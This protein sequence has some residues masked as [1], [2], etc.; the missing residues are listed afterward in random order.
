MPESIVS[1]ANHPLISTENDTGAI[2]IPLPLVAG[3]FAIAAAILVV[4]GTA[5]LARPDQTVDA[6][7]AATLPAS[8]P[9]VATIAVGELAAG[10][11]ALVIGGP[12]PAIAVLGLYLGFLAFILISRTRG[13]DVGG[14]GCLGARSDTPPGAI[15]VTFNLIAALAAAIA[16]IA[17]V[18]DITTIVTDDALDGMAYIAF[19]GLGT[20]LS[21]VLLTDLPRLNSIVE[22]GMG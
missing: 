22:R 18:P 8:K 12:W 21:V 11:S 9:A 20:W 5:K 19:V 13:A 16:I 3:P 15:H 17:A 6:L 2:L 10:L 14:C 4:S 1:G 7:R